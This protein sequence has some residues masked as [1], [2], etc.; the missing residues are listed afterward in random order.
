V[1]HEAGH[2]GPRRVGVRIGQYVVTA[3]LM[4]L[5]M[6]SVDR[7]GLSQLLIGLRWELVV[8]S[9]L[10][11]AGCHLTN[12]YRWWSLIPATTIGFG[13]VLTMYGAGLF[14]NNFLPTGIG[15]DGIRTALLSRRLPLAQSLLSV[16][17]DRFVG[18]VAL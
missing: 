7:A 18:C 6:Q 13:S 11:V 10:L 9:A 4:T 17:L 2:A 14:S 16:V 15:G 8:S 1:K 12:I 5:I 3:G